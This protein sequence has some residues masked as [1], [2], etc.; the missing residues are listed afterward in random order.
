M[1]TNSFA[2]FTNELRMYMIKNCDQLYYCGKNLPLP[3][4]EQRLQDPVLEMKHGK[5][6]TIAGGG[7]RKKKRKK[8]AQPR[9]SQEQLPRQCGHALL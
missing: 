9:R 3:G 2:K 4:A 5:S 1:Q 8:N 6:E 7:K